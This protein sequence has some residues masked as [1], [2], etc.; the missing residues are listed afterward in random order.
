MKCSLENSGRNLS[1]HFVLMATSRWRGSAKRTLMTRVAP[2]WTSHCGS[3]M[4]TASLF[5]TIARTSFRLWNRSVKQIRATLM[6]PAGTWRHCSALPP[7]PTRLRR[8]PAP[9]GVGRRHVRAPARVTRPITTTPR[10]H[11]A[12]LCRISARKEPSCPTT[13][14][15][16]PTPP[17]RPPRRP[18][19]CVEHKESL[20]LG[21]VAQGITGSGTVAPIIGNSPPT[22]LDA[23]R[24]RAFARDGR[25]AMRLPGNHSVRGGV[26]RVSGG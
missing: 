14:P 19:P 18:R 17:P 6:K 12:G 26:W 21:A 23:V 8:R 2:F 4:R 25:V 11:G 20:G 10:P 16:R 15:R 1:Q 13:P 24:R 22:M 5:P 3:S 7:D 9:P